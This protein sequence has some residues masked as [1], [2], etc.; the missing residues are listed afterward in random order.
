MIDRQTGRQ[1]DR[2]TDRQVDVDLD[3]DID[4]NIL[5]HKNFKTLY[6]SIL[7]FGALPLSQDINM[8]PKNSGLLYQQIRIFM[9]CYK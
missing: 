6:F 9:C 1:I 7:R 2:Q 3:V 4:I 5:H 8:I